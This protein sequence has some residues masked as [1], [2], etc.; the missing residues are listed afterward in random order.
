[1]GL[2]GTTGLG[3]GVSEDSSVSIESNDSNLFCSMMGPAAPFCDP[4]FSDPFLGGLTGILSLAVGLSLTGIGEADLSLCPWRD[5]SGDTAVICFKVFC[6]ARPL[7]LLGGVSLGLLPPDV[8]F[9]FEAFGLRPRGECV[10]ED[11]DEDVV[12]G[13]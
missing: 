8:G 1:M 5:R 12:E 2:R 13:L 6:L 7:G 10:C 3:V 4:G 11:D 9:G